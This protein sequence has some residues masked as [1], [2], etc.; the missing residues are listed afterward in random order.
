MLHAQRSEGRFFGRRVNCEQVPLLPA[1]AVAQVFD[2]PEETPYLLV[3][4]DSAGPV[5]EC[6]YLTPHDS[7]VPIA[8]NE[9]SIWAERDVETGE[10]EITRHD[11]TTDIIGTLL[12]PLPRN[13]GSVRLLIC[14]D[15]LTPRR[16]LYGWEPE[17][18]T[19]GSTRASRGRV[20]GVEPATNCATRQRAAHLCFVVVDLS[21]GCSAAVAVTAPSR[22][23]PMFSHRRKGHVRSEHDREPLPIR[24]QRKL[25]RLVQSKTPKLGKMPPG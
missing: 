7:D 11:G 20:G 9:L 10:V 21:R 4:R 13:R 15:C 23:F 25:D 5:R 2:D 22:G 3:W 24:S 1:W 14:P 8:T 12:R 16:G 17:T 6:A 18:K 19:D